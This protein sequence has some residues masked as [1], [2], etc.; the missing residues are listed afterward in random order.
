MN[1]A[2]IFAGGKGERLG[3]SGESLPKQFLEID[4]K[5]ILVHTLLK[6][7]NKKPLYN[8]EMESKILVFNRSLSVLIAIGFLWLNIQDK[9]YIPEDEEDLKH[10]N[11]Q[12]DASLLNLIGSLIVLYVALDSINDLNSSDFDNPAL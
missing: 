11:L 7:Q 3:G 1:I 8:S 6:F 10:A 4:K 12:I 5:P 2:I 9:K